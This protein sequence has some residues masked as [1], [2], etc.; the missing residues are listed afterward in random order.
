M[1]RMSLGGSG[2]KL[3]QQNPKVGKQRH[4]QGLVSGIDL[5]S[6]FVNLK[7]IFTLHPWLGR[8]SELPSEAD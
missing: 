7:T 6:L 1:T 2:V 8:V 4:D 5:A 3:I